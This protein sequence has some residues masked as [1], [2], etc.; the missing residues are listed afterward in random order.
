M[1]SPAPV[2]VRP[3]AWWTSKTIWFAVLQILLAISVQLGAIPGLP[4]S[5]SAYFGATG[6][7]TMIL[8]L[9]TNAPVTTSK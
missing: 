9:L 4:A 1:N 8:R 5:V 6:L 2:A 7:I 3:K